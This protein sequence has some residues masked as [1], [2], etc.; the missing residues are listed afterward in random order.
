MA[1]QIFLKIYTPWGNDPIWRAFRMGWVCRFNHQLR[2][3]WLYPPIWGGIPQISLW[4]LPPCGWFFFR[5]ASV[6]SNAH[7]CFWV[8]IYQ[9]FFGTLGKPKKIE[10]IY[11]STNLFWVHISTEKITWKPSV[12]TIPL[13]F[14]GFFPAIIGPGCLCQ[15]F[16]P[17]GPGEVGVLGNR[18][19]ASIPICGPW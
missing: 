15:D 17:P 5:F 4:K 19:I 16:D 7:K 18:S 11:I 8:N 2:S 1:T 14:F 12:L 13:V 10:D 9:W 6:R 3:H